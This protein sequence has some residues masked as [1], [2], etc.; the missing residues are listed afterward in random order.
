MVPVKNSLLYADAMAQ[1]GVPFEMHIYPG[2]KHGLG[3]ADLMTNPEIKPGW[4]NIRDWLDALCKWL[5]R[6]LQTEY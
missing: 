5:R 4:E 6:T 3:T 2:G 1:N